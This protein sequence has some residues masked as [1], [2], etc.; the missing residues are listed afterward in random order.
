MT[1]PDPDALVTYAARPTPRYT[2]YPTAPHFQTDF[3]ESVYRQWLGGLAPKRPVSLYV[4]V[5]FCASMCWYCGCNMKLSA[6]YAPVSDYVTSLLE[7]A[8]LVSAAA[9]AGLCAGRLHFGGGTPNA[10]TPKDLERVVSRLDVLFAPVPDCE[11]AIEIDP[12]TLSPDMARAIGNLGFT[13]ASFGVQEFDPAVQAA[14]NRI[15]PPEMVAAAMDG[16]RDAGVGSFSFDLIYGLPHQTEETLLRTV[17][18]C[19]AMGPDR[20]SLFGYAHVPWMAKNQRLIDEAA[21][22]DT[23]ARAAQADAAAGALVAAGYRR[24]GIDHFALPQD[25][26]ARAADAGSLHRNFQG[27]T[28]DA[29][30]TLLGFGATAIGRLPQ[31]HVQN[32][33]ETGAW[34]RAIAAGRLPVEKGRAFAGE[35]RLRGWVIERLMCDGAADLDAAGRL[36]GA[37]PRWWS[38]EVAALER[39]ARD[40]IVTLEGAGVRLTPAGRPLARIAAAVFDAYLHPQAGAPRRHSAAV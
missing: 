22:P 4:H 37:S 5:P 29:C 33:G 30:E 12:R 10:L 34:S 19:V 38:A 25:S 16:L 35:D 32:I 31:G 17:A 14:I 15:Q 39:L 2:S 24:I 1:P 21:L 7:E 8:A 28:D 23:H 11:R 18:R 13:R 36:F 20:V 9:P 26:L 6:R 40:G 3:P 27:Y